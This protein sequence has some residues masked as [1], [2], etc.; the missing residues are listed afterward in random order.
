MTAILF[1]IPRFIFGLSRTLD[2]GGTFTAYNQSKSPSEAD[3]KAI[4]SDWNTVGNDLRF[5]LK[6]G[7]ADLKPIDNAA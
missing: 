2:I 3:W 6:K 5:A 4:E 1:A 7:M